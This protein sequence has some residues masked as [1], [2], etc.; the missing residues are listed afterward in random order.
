MNVM[1]KCKIL[2]DAAGCAIHASLINICR[3]EATPKFCLGEF[4]EISLLR[5]EQFPSSLPLKSLIQFKLRYSS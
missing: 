3:K 2:R 1:V 5:T 4:A